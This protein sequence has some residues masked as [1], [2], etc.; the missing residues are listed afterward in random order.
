MFF[1]FLLCLTNNLINK[2]YVFNKPAS[3]NIKYI[4]KYNLTELPANNYFDLKYGDSNSILQTHNFYNNHFRKV[5]LTYFKSDDKELFSSIWYPSYN[6]DCPIL[7]MDLVKFSHNISLC[8]INLIE[9]YN[10][11]EYYN[12]YI[13]P[14][15]EIKNDYPELSESTSKQLL[16]FKNFLSKAMLYGHIYNNSL[17]DTSVS[18]ALDRYLDEYGK[19]FIRRPVIRYHIE[20]VHQDYNKLKHGI[21]K[22]FIMK[23][24]FD[25]KWYEQLIDNYY[26]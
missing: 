21:D 4:E 18:N 23:D 7:N 14:F 12:N 5:R 3:I 17:I 11:K 1:T 10:S 16:P 2:N 25:K 9:I 8:F 6:Y 20:E 19:M 22:N 13:K 15:M 24:Y 26:G